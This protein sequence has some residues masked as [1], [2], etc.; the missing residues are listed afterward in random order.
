[1]PS[2]EVATVSVFVHR[3]FNWLPSPHCIASFSSPAFAYGICR[4]F[5]NV[6]ADTKLPRSL[7]QAI[8][9]TFDTH[10]TFAANKGNGTATGAASVQSCHARADVFTLPLVRPGGAAIL[11]FTGACYLVFARGRLSR[12][13]SGCRQRY[14]ASVFQPVLEA[15]GFFRAFMPGSVSCC[16][17]GWCHISGPACWLARRYQQPAPLRQILYQTARVTAA[18][19]DKASSS[20]K[21][22]KN[23]AARD[24]YGW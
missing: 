17:S 7:G 1:M 4:P 14:C 23:A 18:Q 12:G 11:S 8:F 2:N 20:I 10:L 9:P 22:I 6:A 15:T 19:T 24:L 5:V 16:A 13:V 21:F 3:I